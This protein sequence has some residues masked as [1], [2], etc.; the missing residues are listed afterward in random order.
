MI[1]MVLTVWRGGVWAHLPIECHE[2]PGDNG[3]KW[4]KREVRRLREV[5]GLTDDVLI[6]RTWQGAT[7]C[8]TSARN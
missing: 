5:Y 7:A 6:I 1:P 2:P 3:E 4:W 8:D